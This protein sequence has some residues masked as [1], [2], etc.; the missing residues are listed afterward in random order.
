MARLSDLMKCVAQACGVS[1]ASARVMARVLRESGLVSKG[2]RGLNAAQ[3]SAT[4]VANILIG[5]AVPCDAT[6]LGSAVANVGS[7]VLTGQAPVLLGR[8]LLSCDI[9]KCID[10][11][12][13]RNGDLLHDSISRILEHYY[14]KEITSV[15]D[16]VCGSADN[17]FNNIKSKDI[18]N[19]KKIINMTPCRVYFEI[20]QKLSGFKCDL[21][22]EGL[23][24][25]VYRYAF[26][27]S[28]KSIK[29]E[30]DMSID[31]GLDR[32]VK[33]NSYIFS[34][35]VKCMRS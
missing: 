2:G 28:V 27:C 11:V 10:P 9:D 20:Y 19:N 26:R 13:L 29:F 30:D 31:A 23:D 7:L 3:M 4:D 24:G 33:L 8:G 5:F 32:T 12:K 1:E 16:N 21:T 22:V 17:N 14:F 15:E 18:N 6:K 25:D 34:E 35:A